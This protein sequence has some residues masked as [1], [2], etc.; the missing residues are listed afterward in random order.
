MS[1]LRAPRGVH[2]AELKAKA[3]K[4][5]LQTEPRLSAAAIGRQLGISKNGVIGL[6]NRNAWPRRPSPIKPGTGAKPRPKRPPPVDPPQ[7][8]GQPQ[9]LARPTRHF[10]T[11]QYVTTAA[12]P[13]KFCDAPLEAGQSVYCAQHAPRM[14]VSA[15]KKVPEWRRYP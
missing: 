15:P 7:P 10:A 2:T 8:P 12:P 1:G 3:L 13:H 6:A 5:W 9:R 4:L 14:T 11:C